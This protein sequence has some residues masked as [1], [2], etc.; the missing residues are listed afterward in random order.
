MVRV[1]TDPKPV[2]L[3]IEFGDSALK[4]QLRFWIA[5]AQNG[6]QNVKSAVLLRIWEK[7]KEA[8]IEVPYPQRDL[9]VRSGAEALAGLR[10]A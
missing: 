3:F 5:D 4:L 7:F 8:D 10:R 6:V 1:L 9:H 2:C